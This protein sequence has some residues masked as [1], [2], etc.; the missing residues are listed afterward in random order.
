MAV[1]EFLRAVSE[2]FGPGSRCL[3][4]LL[5]LES[6]GRALGSTA[7][8][9]ITATSILLAGGAGAGSGD[10]LASRALMYKGVVEITDAGGGGG[11]FMTASSF[12]F[13]DGGSSFG[14]SLFP[15]PPPAWAILD[16][17][18]IQKSMSNDWQLL[19][20][21]SVHRRAD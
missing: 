20:Q 7:C 4:Q 9:G 15:G 10:M 18:K 8:G 12:A 13:V 17:I 19:M 5:E 3:R 1:V 2:G 21:N 11:G 14:R 16:V 6:R